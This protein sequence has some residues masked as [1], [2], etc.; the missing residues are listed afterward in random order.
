MLRRAALAVSAMTFALAAASTGARAAETDLLRI[1]SLFPYNAQT[2]DTM[3]FEVDVEYRKTDDTAGSPKSSDLMLTALAAFSPIP[4]LEVG[5]TISHV[6]RDFDRDVL[7]SPS[8]PTDAFAWGKYRFYRQ[9]D[10]MFTVGAFA[11]LP[12]GEEDDGLGTGNVDPGVFLSAGT[13]T[14][15]NAF[16]EASIGLRV[17]GD[18]ESRFARANG[19]TS[20]LVDLGAVMTASQGFD[21]FAGFALETERYDGGDSFAQLTGGGRWQISGPWRLQAQAGLGL[22]DAAPKVSLGIGLVFT[23]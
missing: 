7:G 20:V 6:S 19:K 9:Q 11:S 22:G 8:G 2:I 12:T 13:R 18:L 15:G 10:T 1:P 17:N 4:E 3:W 21:A 23:P 5:A 14:A 16:V